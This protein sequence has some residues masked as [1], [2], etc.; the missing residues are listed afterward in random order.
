MLSFIYKVTTKTQG[1]VVFIWNSASNVDIAASAGVVG[2]AA[3]LAASAAVLKFQILYKFL[4][5]K[6]QALFHS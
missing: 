5:M 1:L 3:E 6:N 4:I 2:L